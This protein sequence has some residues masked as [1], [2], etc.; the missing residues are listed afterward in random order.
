MAQTIDLEATARA[1]SGK[2]AAR[3]ARRDGMVPGVIYGG[4]EDP[5]TINIKHNVLLK[6]LKAGKFL[7]TL[8][9]LDVDGKV[10]TVICRA[11][12][13]DVVRDLPIHVD[14]LRLSERS[15]ISLYIPV[16]FINHDKAPGIRRGGVLTVVRPEVE[17]KV[18]A[19]NIPDHLTVDLSGLNVGDVVKISNVALPEGTSPTITDR[20]FVI[21]NIS[22]PSALVSEEAEESAEEE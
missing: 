1:G 9:K 17:L 19:A 11:V 6:R 13:R 3:S 8:I 2:G 5:V 15:R 21:A 18:S 14:F 20:D 4:G 12:Q 16:E 22:A 10:H 7:S